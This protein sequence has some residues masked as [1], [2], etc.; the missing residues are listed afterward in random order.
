MPAFSPAMAESS[1]DICPAISSI[2]DSA[3]LSTSKTP[4]FFAAHMP[5]PMTGEGVWAWTRPAH[6]KESLWAATWSLAL[7][8][9][10]WSSES[11][12]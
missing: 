4:S 5:A 3:A 2:A 11:S 7:L 1:G 6:F 10:P 8:S 12:Q 9:A